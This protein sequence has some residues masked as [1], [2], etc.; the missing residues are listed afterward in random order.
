MQFKFYSPF[1]ICFLIGFIFILISFIELI[2]FLNI[3]NCNIKI[4]LFFSFFVLETNEFVIFI[5]ICKFILRSINLFLK[6]RT[7]N[8]F[9]VFHIIIFLS[10]DDFIL[11]IFNIFTLY[12]IV[13]EVALLIV[14]LAFSFEIFAVFTFVE[15]IELNCCGLNHNLKKNIVDRGDDEKKSFY[16]PKIEEEEEKEDEEDSSA[17]NSDNNANSQ[18][19]SIY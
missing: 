13:L 7:I 18:N 17:I 15:I 3:N 2:I 4:C 6:V 1:F 19:S 9:S 8:D 11:N 12:D 16:L 5:Y 10:L 14:I